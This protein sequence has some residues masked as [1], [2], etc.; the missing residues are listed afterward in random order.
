[1]S[2]LLHFNI[3]PDANFSDRISNGMSSTFRIDQD[4]DACRITTHCMYPSNGLVRVYVRCG[5]N[6][7]VASD[8]GEALGEASAAGIEIH[9]A[10]KQLGNFVRHR[11]LI[12]RSGIIMTETVP[13]DA[14]GIA[15]SHVANTAKE[16]AHWLYEHG[17]I[18]RRRDFRKLLSDFL[19][20]NFRHNVSSSEVIGASHKLHKFQNVISFANGR[21]LIVD[22]ASNE[23][24][25]INAKAIA[26]IDV[27]AQNDPMITQRIVYDDAQLWAA[28]DLAI[29][30]MG[31]T[32]IPF[33]RAKAAIPRIAEE[34]RGAA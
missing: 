20:E 9:D 1:M 31:A 29:L 14:V 6:V 4:E 10:D 13:F 27:R 22:A 5:Q 8:E 19:V 21:K 23:P 25:S 32:I 2:D 3:R 24:S 15:V 17:G 33:S 12:L 7:V 34:T 26:N 18:K 11:G 28:A 30:Q 16:A